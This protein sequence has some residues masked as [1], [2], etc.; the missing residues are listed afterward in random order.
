MFNSPFLNAQPA[1]QGFAAPAPNP[2]YYVQGAPYNIPFQNQYPAIVNGY[3]IKMLQDKAQMNPLRTYMFNKASDNAWQNQ[4]F[5]ML[6]SSTTV[7]ADALAQTQASQNNS[8]EQ[9]VL[10]AANEV[11]NCA[12]VAVAQEA[13]QIKMMM[14]NG[15]DQELNALIQRQQQIATLIA[16]VAQQNQFQQQQQHHAPFNAQQAPQWN[17]SANTQGA[18]P[19]NQ[20]SW[21]APAPAGNA[22][23]NWGRFSNNQ[24]GG[25]APAQSTYSPQGS[26]QG[27]SGLSGQGNG[28]RQQQ[29]QPAPAPAHST[30]DAFASARGRSSDWPKPAGGAAIVETMFEDMG[31][32]PAATTNKQQQAFS[33]TMRQQEAQRQAEL[34]QK[35]VPEQYNEDA[36]KANVANH[37]TIDISRPY[38]KVVLDNGTEIRPAHSSGW[39]R[40]WS[41]EE[42][43][44]L[45]FDPNT[46]MKFHIRTKQADGSFHV[47]EVVKEIQE[48]EMESMG[49]LQNEIKGRRPYVL[50][51][52]KRV[53]PVDWN[54]VATLDQPQVVVDPEDGT[55]SPVENPE[56]KIIPEEITA[57]S[58]AE[59]EVKYLNEVI[60]FG[61]ESFEGKSR[62]YYYREMKPVAVDAPMIGV[63]IELAKKT[64]LVG[65]S[66]FLRDHL[67]NEKISV[68]LYNL[69]NSELT[70]RTN[71]ALAI[72][73]GYGDN[74]QIA[75][76]TMDIEALGNELHVDNMGLLWTLL[77][78]EHAED[79]IKATTNILKGDDY[80]DYLSKLGK[81]MTRENKADV[82]NVLAR[83]DL[84]SVT[85]LPW[86][87]DLFNENAQVLKSTD[88]KALH[89]A[90]VAILNRTDKAS[91]KFSRHYVIDIND[92]AVEILPGYLGRESVLI[93]SVTL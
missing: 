29:E 6:I 80:W 78:T 51:P 71:E 18:W 43:W 75:D 74:L 28:G 92:R 77:N 53:M 83:Y 36:F 8:Q 19:N 30:T 72:N 5:E 38:D 85:H 14:G 45:A 49:Y 46:H 33:E 56:V 89:A 60:G 22:N 67:E 61:S 25:G 40:T 20:P 81:N 16:Q 35:P 13:P 68:R 90:M 1:Q 4:F 57:H 69:L 79:I 12:M 84:V 42:P 54:E 64:T 93:R 66:K 62:E 39:E 9:L 17:T 59:A 23:I 73:L 82:N 21:T 76:F 34:Q 58:F 86:A 32:A 55:E 50:D 3:V 70:K 7:L 63:M 2:A 10:N 37:D 11:V 65:A 41:L 24:N 26:Y 31:E 47:K 44:P 91:T 27:R 88:N 52:T 87:L 15:V 48:N